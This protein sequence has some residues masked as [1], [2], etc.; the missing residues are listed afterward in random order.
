MDPGHPAWPPQS[1]PARP[2][3]HAKALIREHRTLVLVGET[4]S[5]KT[6]QIPQFLYEAGYGRGA[7]GRVSSRQA[8]GQA[9]WWG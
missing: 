7:A 8:V 5:G 6:T 1:P 2:C 4:G 9:G 3:L